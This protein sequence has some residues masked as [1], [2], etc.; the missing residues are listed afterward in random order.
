MAAITMLTKE[1]ILRQLSREN[2]DLGKNPERTFVYYQELGLIPT[3]AKGNI[4]TRNR[5]LLF[6]DWAPKLIKTIKRLQEEGKKL[7]EIKAVLDE[8]QAIHK[9]IREKL[10]LD[11]D[12]E[13]DFYIDFGQD[14]YQDKEVK[15]CVVGAFYSDKIKWFKIENVSSPF[16]IDEN[17]RIVDTRTMTFR[18]YGECIK[19]LAIGIAKE[20]KRVL[21][22]DDVV[23]AIFVYPSKSRIGE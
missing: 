14:E 1:E 17:F 18:E 9:T 20:N 7:S 21:K 16:F 6:P 19:N 4:S 13:L 15:I 23:K 11:E 2:V 12:E 3:K 22:N 10:S 5:K 8:S